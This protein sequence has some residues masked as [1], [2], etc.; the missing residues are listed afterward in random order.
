MGLAYRIIC[1]MCRHEH[2]ID[3]EWLRYHGAASF[4]IAKPRLRCRK[5]KD[6][7]FNVVV[8]PDLSTPGMGRAGKKLTPLQL[9]FRRKARKRRRGCQFARRPRLIRRRA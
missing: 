7:R 2:H 1:K 6:R 8:S 4:Q 9:L 3:D 5:C